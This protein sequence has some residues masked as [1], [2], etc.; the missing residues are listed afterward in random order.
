[1][2]VGCKLSSYLLAYIT[3]TEHARQ[4]TST[5][6]GSYTKQQTNPVVIIYGGGYVTNL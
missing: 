2:F 1:M 6:G 4:K 3:E 5:K